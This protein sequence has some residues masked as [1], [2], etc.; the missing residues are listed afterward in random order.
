MTLVFSRILLWRLAQYPN[1]RPVNVLTRDW[2][3]R[4]DYPFS[5]EDELSL[6]ACQSQPHRP[7]GIRVVFAWHTRFS[8]GLLCS[9][10]CQ[11]TSDQDALFLGQ[12][13]ATLQDGSDCG[14]R[15]R[16][17]GVQVNYWVSTNSRSQA[18]SRLR[19]MF[20]TRCTGQGEL[21]I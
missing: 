13:H 12:S 11:E 3:Q 21:C 19:D 20:I 14:R 8:S 6:V 7:R 17:V 4:L 1:G 15:V 9:A 10:S 2:L 18:S 5:E 16:R